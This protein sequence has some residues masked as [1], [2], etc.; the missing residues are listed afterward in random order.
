MGYR[1][2]AAGLLGWAGI[3]AVAWHLADKRIGLCYELDTKCIIATTADRDFIL[4]LGL[5]VA[6]IAMIWVAVTWTRRNGRLERA[7]E[8]FN[9]A[10]P[11]PPKRLR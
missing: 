3:V 10:S 1:I 4:S 6:L 7:P 2:I 11:A 8:I 9:A 5:S